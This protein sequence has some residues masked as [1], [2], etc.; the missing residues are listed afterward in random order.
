MK[1]TKK[2]L[3]KFDLSN[4]KNKNPGKDLPVGPEYAQVAMFRHFIQ[5]GGTLTKYLVADSFYAGVLKAR[6]RLREVKGISD[7]DEIPSQL[8][9]GDTLYLFCIES[10]GSGNYLL[11]KIVD[12]I[13]QSSFIGGK[14]ANEDDLRTN[15]SF[16]EF[17]DLL[18]ILLF[19][20]FADIETVV[21]PAGQSVTEKGTRYKNQ[22]KSDVTILDCRWFTEIIRT[23]GFSV[24]GH[25]RMQPFGS[26]KS[27]KKLI[28]INEF[29]KTGYK[30]TPST[31]G[32][33][34]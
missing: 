13:A 2:I 6:E 3:R 5:E 32:N 14:D 29:S 27:Q 21:V 12:G 20:K 19:K 9:I 25:F 28:W 24:T 10:S 1:I 4:V 18:N 15:S 22:A 16:S 33:S 11:C 8:L 34:L 23:E 26:E 7:L 30:Y 17:E 31:P